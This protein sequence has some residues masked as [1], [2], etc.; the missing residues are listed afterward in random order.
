MIV[1]LC[2]LLLLFVP[3]ILIS[4]ESHNN[5]YPH[6]QR[7]FIDFLN[8]TRRLFPGRIIEYIIPLDLRLP[9]IIGWLFK[10]SLLVL[11]FFSIKS[12]LV[13][14]ALREITPLIIISLIILFFFVFILYK[15]GGFSI[16]GRYTT[17]LFIPVFLILVFFFRFVKPQLLISWFIFF[18][19]LFIGENINRN[20]GLYKNIDFRS[21]KNY[22]EL[23]EKSNEPIF[24]YRNIMADNLAI[25]YKGVNEIVPVPEAFSYNIYSPEE[26]KVNEQDIDKLNEK[27]IKYVSFYFVLDTFPLPGV[28]ES[29]P[30][31]LNFLRNNFTLEEKEFFKGHIELYKF[32]NKE[33]LS[34]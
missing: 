8:E 21:L 22:I 13:K 34:D 18:A 31:L 24:V 25:Y 7:S 32:S 9:K 14:K 10:I 5:I 15:F 12:G 16:S 26:W 1:P 3:Q 20:I 6:Y 17:I 27:M 4:A 30:L 33:I 28:V 2:L 11:M 19:L 23:H 29:K